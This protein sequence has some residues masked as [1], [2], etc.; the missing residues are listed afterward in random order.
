MLL[1]HS[2]NVNAGVGAFFGTPLHH[3]VRMGDIG[4]IEL[5]I[6]R[7]ADINAV[8]D[9]GRT[10]LGIA[11]LEGFKNIVE[12]L[13]AKGANV[14][15]VERDGC[16]PLHLLS[17]KRNGGEGPLRG[18]IAQILIE[19]GANVNAANKN[20]DTPLHGAAHMCDGDVMKVLIE[21]GANVNARNKQVRYND[22][23]ETPLAVLRGVASDRSPE[24]QLLLRHGG[25]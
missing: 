17:G 12:F 2:A 21:C 6:A 10:P 9:C 11:V 23:G 16:T 7:G 18:Q 5:L 4:F 19:H 1:S 25:V 20:G 22:G 15:A 24:F 13:I 3:A 8:E 14:N